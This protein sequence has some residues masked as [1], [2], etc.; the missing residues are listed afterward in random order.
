MGEVPHSLICLRLLLGFPAAGHRCAPECWIQDRT[1]MSNRDLMMMMAMMTDSCWGFDR[2][3]VDSWQCIMILTDWSK[4]EAKNRGRK[5]QSLDICN[6][7]K[8]RFFPIKP[9]RHFDFQAQFLFF[10]TSPA[11]TSLSLSQ[12]QM[13]FRHLSACLA[14]SICSEKMA[15]NY[16]NHTY[17]DK[18]HQLQYVDSGHTWQFYIIIITILF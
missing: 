11:P 18:S 4:E 15:D 10:V 6:H 3:K 16:H 13:D 9:H 1:I 5:L 7:H 12:R 8:C 17:I 2:L 14:I